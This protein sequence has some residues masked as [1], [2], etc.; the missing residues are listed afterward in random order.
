MVGNSKTIPYKGIV[1]QTLCAYTHQQ[2]RVTEQ[3]NHHLLEVAHSLTSFPSYIWGDVILTAAHLI[4]RMPSCILH[5]QTPLDCLK[6]SYPST[7][8]VSEGESVSE[9]SNNTFKFIKPT[10]STVFDSPAPVQDSEPPQDQEKNRGEETE[11]RTKTS[12]NEAKHGHTGKLDEYDPSLDILIALRKASI[13]S[14][15]IPKSIY[16]TL[17]YPEC[18]NPIMEEMKAPE[19]NRALEIFTL[20]KGRRTL[21]VK[22][23]FLNGDLV[24]EVYMR[25]LQDLKPIL[26][27]RFTTFVKSQGCS[28]GHSNHTLFT[29]VSKTEKIVV[30]IVY[31]DDIILTGD[32]QT[33]ICQLKQR[34]GDESEIKDLENLKYFLGIEV[35]K[36]KEGISVSQRKYTLDLL[37]KTGMLGCRPADTPIEFNCKPGNFDDQ[38]L[39][40]KEQYQRLVVAI[41]IAN[42]P[43]RHDRTKY[44]EIDRH[45]IKERLDNGS[46]CIPNIPSSQQVA[47]VLTK[48]CPQR[49]K[50]PTLS[51]IYRI[52]HCLS[53]PPCGSGQVLQAV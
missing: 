22:N 41:S 48:R 16:T 42:S 26:F 29:K 38:V 5:L 31:V 9:E 44:V 32:D 47:D 10:P 53:L 1:H 50:T 11:V 39:D 12:N 52:S 20:P 34:I 33:E 28:Q 17:K 27:S 46:I 51:C 43:I 40:D 49:K 18:K 15:I 35:A 30:L 6:E 2:N 25:P 14:A 23:A 4:N 45:F 19:K 24:E 3:K 36:S 37:T 21:D 8:L 13:D 7:R